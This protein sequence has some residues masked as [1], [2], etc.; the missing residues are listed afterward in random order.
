MPHLLI[1]VQV[2]GT[3]RTAEEFWQLQQLLCPPSSLSAGVDLALFR[4]GVTL[5]SYPAQVDPGLSGVARLGG[6]GQH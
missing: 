3:L 1:H 2:V 5:F 4:A 6:C